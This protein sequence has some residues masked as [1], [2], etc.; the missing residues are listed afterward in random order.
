MLI[1]AASADLDEDPPR[2]AAWLRI[3]AGFAGF[4]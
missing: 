4:S 2:D 3:L 1:I